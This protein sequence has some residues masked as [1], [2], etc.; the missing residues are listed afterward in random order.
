MKQKHGDVLGPERRRPGV[1][2]A[3]GI[4]PAQHRVRAP[5][6]PPTVEI[7]RPG[8]ETRSQA[9][10]HGFDHRLAFVRAHPRRRRDIG[11]VGAGRRRLPRSDFGRRARGRSKLADVNVLF[12]RDP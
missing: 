6:P 10:H 7:V 9:G 4:V 8:L 11:P 3:R 12:F 1:G 5:Q 2:V